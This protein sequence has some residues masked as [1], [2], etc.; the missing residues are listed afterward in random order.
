MKAKFKLLPALLLSMG[1]VLSACSNEAS[2]TEPTPTPPDVTEYGYF[3]L[4]FTDL[5]SLATKANDD[6][7]GLADESNISELRVVLYSTTTNLPAYAF[8]YAITTAGDAVTGTITSGG[9]T[10]P[11]GSQHTSGGIKS[12]ST[13]SGGITTEAEYIKATAYKL[14]V[15]V[16]PT[17][18][19]K[20]A[21][22]VGSGVTYAQFKNKVVPTLTA[23]E[24]FKYFTEGSTPG[25]NN[26]FFMTNFQDFVDV[27]AT[28]LKSS[29]T[30]A[31]ASGAPKT[32]YVERAV[33]KVVFTNPAKKADD[34]TGVTTLPGVTLSDPNWRLD[35][36]NKTSYF[37][38]HITNMNT[39]GMEV[40]TNP[41]ASALIRNRFYGKTRT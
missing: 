29:K 28:D 2:D 38:R 21:T 26:K 14:L 5:A 6:A 15:L 25:T 30:A 34:F 33:A 35:I 17:D 41:A 8:T 37:M 1:V 12:G 19:A 36:T 31:E 24:E 4:G 20:T 39:G 18:E 9:T 40:I 23:K 3:S 32:V 7:D 27:A 13:I 22:N 11:A 16:N 10:L